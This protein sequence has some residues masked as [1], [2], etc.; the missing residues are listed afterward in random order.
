[1]PPLLEEE[2][3]SVGTAGIMNFVNPEFLDRSG[4]WPAFTSN[5]GPIDASQIDRANRTDQRLERNE[6]DC[7]GNVSNLVDPIDD[8][9]VLHT[10]S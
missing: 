3:G 4:P 7:S 10:G 9:P 5:D 8:V 6:P 1:M 2:R